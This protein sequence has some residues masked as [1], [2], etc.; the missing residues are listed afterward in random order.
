MGSY[1]ANGYGLYDMAGNVWEWTCSDYAKAYDG[2][3]TKCSSGSGT[4]RA[5]R[6]GSW[7]FYPYGLRSANRYL[8]TP[9]FRDGDL[10]LRLSR[11]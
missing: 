9:D 10:G 6:G 2:S 8:N 5:I 1:S 3:E 11:M 7:N 4:L